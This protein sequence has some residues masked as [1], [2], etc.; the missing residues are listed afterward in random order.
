MC[1]YNGSV[2]VS[3]GVIHQEALRWGL[4]LRPPHREPF[5]CHLVHGDMQEHER[6]SPQA[7]RKPAWSKIGL[8]NKKKKRDV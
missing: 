8:P 5:M 2:S 1:D 3:W 6:V 7:S 4:R